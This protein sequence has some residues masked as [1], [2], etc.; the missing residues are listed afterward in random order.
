MFIMRIYISALKIKKRWFGGCNF[1]QPP[2]FYSMDFIHIFIIKMIKNA[3]RQVLFYYDKIFII[4]IF[5]EII[6]TRECQNDD[7]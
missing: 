1:G 2:F 3:D 4:E 7:L 6:K 5:T